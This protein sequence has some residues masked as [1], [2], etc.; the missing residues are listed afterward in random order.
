M[1]KQTALTSFF[2]RKRAANGEEKVPD[3]SFRGSQKRGR[4]L[5]GGDP[6]TLVCWNSNGLG[7]R[8]RNERDL[9]Q[10]SDFVAEHRPDVLCISEARL[11][12]GFGGGE[13]G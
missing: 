2:G 11:V 1:G 4:I 13:A 10:L 5:D 12:A 8:L 3:G 9:K 6:E 7:V